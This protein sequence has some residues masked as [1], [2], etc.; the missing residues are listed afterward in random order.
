LLLQRSHENSFSSFYLS[1]C[2]WM[3]TFRPYEKDWS[4]LLRKINWEREFLISP[5]CPKIFPDLRKNIENNSLSKTS[6]KAYLAMNN[7]LYSINTSWLSICQRLIHCWFK[8]MSFTVV[9]PYSHILFPLIAPSFLHF[10]WLF[11][12][13]L[14][15]F[16]YCQRYSCF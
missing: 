13:I 2:C 3:D 8:V 12:L 4:K 6:W 16:S 10:I 9:I 14:Q 15:P 5:Y 7:T 1:I 11:R